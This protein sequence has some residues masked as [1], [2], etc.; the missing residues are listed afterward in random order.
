MKKLLII[1]ISVIFATLFIPLIIVSCLSGTNYA[2]PET[3]SVYIN[4]GDKVEEMEI[5]QY[6]KCVVAAEMP[7]S[8][9]PEALKAQAVAARTYLASHMQSEAPEQHKGAPVCSDSTHCQA[10][11]SEEKRRESWGAA[12]DGNWDKISRAVEETDGL[13]MTFN[14]KPISAVFHSTSSGKTER[15][16][17]VW[18]EDIPYLQSAESEGD[19]YSP[20]YSSEVRISAE[21]FKR[22]LEENIEGVD[23]SEGLYG[24]IVRSESGGIISLDIGGKSIKGTE[25]RKIFD[26]NSTNA[27]FEEDNGNIKILVKGYGHGVGM[28]QYGADYMAKQGG[29]FEEILKSYYTGVKIEKW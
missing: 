1:I 20:K 22:I 4:S 14:K 13:I 25:F 6:L 21:D 11:I 2:P 26:L 17:D 18:G 24:N 28:S 23:W 3:V 7:V 8:F 16:A 15:A 27:E 29:L 5:N 9:E 19:V 12:A 10:F